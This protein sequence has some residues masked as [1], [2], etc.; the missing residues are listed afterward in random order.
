MAL[1]AGTFLP[2]LPGASE[3]VLAGFLASGNGQPWLLVL[4]ATAGNILGAVINYAAARGISELTDRRWFPV[5]E[6]QLRRASHAFNR[7]GVW[8][9]LLTWLPGIGDVITVIAGLLRTPFGIFFTLTSLGK[10]FRY[11]VIAAGFSFF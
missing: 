4:F 10:L 11:I 7:Y 8:V 6:G 9:L 2:F 5:R 1:V 3:V